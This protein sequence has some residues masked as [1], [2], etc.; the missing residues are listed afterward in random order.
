[1]GVWGQSPWVR[2]VAQPLTKGLWT[3]RAISAA[4]A[5]GI[6]SYSRGCQPWLHLGM[7]WELEINI[8]ARS[9]GKSHLGFSGWEAGPVLVKNCTGF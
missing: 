3:C 4:L 9:L 6:L 1:M 7:A 8:K 2:T 5:G